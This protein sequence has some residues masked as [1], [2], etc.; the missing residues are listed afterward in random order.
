MENPRPRQLYCRSSEVLLPKRKSGT[1]ALQRLKSMR[2]LS[3]FVFFVAPPIYRLARLYRKNIASRFK[4]WRYF[5]VVLT[6]CHHQQSAQN[7]FVGVGE[8]VGVRVGVFVGRRVGVIVGVLDAGRV[9]VTVDVLVAVKVGVGL[10]P[11]A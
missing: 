10:G 8:G 5:G 9:G 6:L 1:F 2:R 3:H 11:A 7:V 4:G